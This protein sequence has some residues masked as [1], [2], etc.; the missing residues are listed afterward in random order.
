MLG[1]LYKDIVSSKK[2]ILLVF[3]L[4]LSI[5]ILYT[6]FYSGPVNELFY[7]ISLLFNLQILARYGYSEEK[8]RIMVLLKTTPI[9]Y[10]EIVNSKYLLALLS[11]GIAILVLICVNWFTSMI[12][13]P[14]ITTVT[15]R[16]VFEFIAITLSANSAAIY[17]YLKYSYY[18][19]QT[20]YL[21]VWVIYILG[22]HHLASIVSSPKTDVAILAIIV[23]INIFLW[24]L[25]YKAVK[26]K[27][28]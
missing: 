21:A 19:M 1:L 4:A 24:I 9:R 3:I 2:Y 23:F 7:F 12:G 8:S 11:N 14:L 15:T 27:R 28:F 26:S 16:F 17:C 20:V 22:R 25:S 6:F 13:R 18:Y 10:S 5:L